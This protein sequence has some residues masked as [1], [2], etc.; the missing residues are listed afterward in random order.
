MGQV[1]F[2]DR[3]MKFLDFIIANHRQSS[4]IIV[5]HRHLRH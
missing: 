3:K 2:T 5:N 4:S 1:D